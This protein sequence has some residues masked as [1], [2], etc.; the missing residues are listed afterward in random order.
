MRT[1]K[2]NRV[3]G[4]PK[5]PEPRRLGLQEGGPQVGNALE[6]RFLVNQ[7]TWISV[8]DSRKWI[9]RLN[10]LTM[11]GVPLPKAPWLH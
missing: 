7:E 3:H 9:V 5:T 4:R 6:K 10:T 2:R 1:P 8:I 11:Y